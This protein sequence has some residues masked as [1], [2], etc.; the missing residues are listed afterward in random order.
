MKSTRAILAMVLILVAASALAQTA[1]V[2]A[3]PLTDEDVKL[4]RQDLQATK[5][6]I[7]KD[8]MGFTGAEAAAFW[9]VYRGYAKE[10]HAIAD[11]RLNLIT[12][13]AQNI[14]KMDNSK[15]SSMTQRLF[16]IEDDTQ[17]LRKAYFSKFESALGAKRAAKFY[18][19]DNRL[20]MLVNLQLA[21]EIPLIP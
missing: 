13:Y 10:Q 20:S 18:Q 21:A 14:D 2:Q 12:E 5:E 19:V 6:D 1:T 15:A 11:R 3:R 4:L 8:T 9:P 7:I 16:K 17:A